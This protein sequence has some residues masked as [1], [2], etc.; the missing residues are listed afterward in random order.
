MS[1]TLNSIRTY[2]DRQTAADNLDSQGRFRNSDR[3]AVADVPLRE[4]AARQGANLRQHLATGRK[5]ATQTRIE[6]AVAGVRAAQNAPAPQARP[7]VA[8]VQPMTQKEKFRIVDELANTVPVGLYALCRASASSAGN[9]ITFLKVYATR[10][11]NRI[12]QLLGAPGAFAEKSLPIDHQYF[13]LKHIAEDAKA[14][15]VL[16]GHETNTCGRCGSPLTS[17]ASRR[18][19]IGPKCQKKGW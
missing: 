10:R 2:A 18:A 12:V 6:A 16:F 7:G 19:G 1:I 17:D 4:V 13:G 15:A 3:T 14:A 5:S 8:S 11:G 9:T